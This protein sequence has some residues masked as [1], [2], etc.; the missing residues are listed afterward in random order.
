MLLLLE[1][2]GL[3]QPDPEIVLDHNLSERFECR[4]TSVKFMESPAIMLKGMAGSVFGV[5]VA[6]GEG[7]FTM[8]NEKVYFLN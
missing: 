1:D 4:F 2:K 6:H 3:S 8:K 5:W 7:R